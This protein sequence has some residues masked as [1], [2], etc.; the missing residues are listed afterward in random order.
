[1]E[2]LSENTIHLNIRYY[3]IKDHIIR[4]ELNVK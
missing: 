2:S 4:K 3:F 1:M